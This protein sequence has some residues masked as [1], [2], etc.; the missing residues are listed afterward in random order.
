M[1][2]I[3]P[4]YDVLWGGPVLA[5]ADGMRW[6][7]VPMLV[8]HRLVGV[9]DDGDGSA[10]YGWCYGSLA[11]I[12]AA[13]AVWDPATQDEPLGWHKRAGEPARRAPERHRDPDHNRARCVHGSYRHTGRCDRTPYCTEFM[14]ETSG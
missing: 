7:A 1:D 5:A 11:A 6:I 3:E 9:P 8:N 10:A 4:S 13:V 14:K 2:L 12:V